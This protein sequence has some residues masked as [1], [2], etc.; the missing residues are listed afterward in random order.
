MKKIYFKIHWSFKEIILIFSLFIF[1]L[2]GQIVY[3][4]LIVLLNYIIVY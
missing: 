3:Y 4:L 1:I 2:T